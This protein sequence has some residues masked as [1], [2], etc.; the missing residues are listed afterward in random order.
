MTE[1]RPLAGAAAGCG[2]GDGS[3]R[4]LGSNAGSGGRSDAPGSSHL[5]G[6]L[7]SSSETQRQRQPE[8]IPLAICHGKVLNTINLLGFSPLCG[9][10]L[11]ASLPL[12]RPAPCSPC[13]G[14]LFVSSEEKK[15][16]K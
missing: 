2:R 13:L 16:Q 15:R 12:Q 6:Y 9:S 8:T 1:Q 11:M 5:F 10:F 4:R 3:L 7:P 14:K